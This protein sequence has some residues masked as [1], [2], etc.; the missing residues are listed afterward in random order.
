MQ[1]SNIYFF[2]IRD[3]YFAYDINTTFCAELDNIA[4]TIL[5]ELLSGA[6]RSLEKK[7]AHVYPMPQLHRCIKECKEL[8][9]SGCFGANP[10]TYKHHIHND[11]AAVCLH[12][13]HNCNLSCEYCYADTGAFGGNRQLMSRRIMFKAIDFAFAHS[14]DFKSVNV[15]FFGGEPLLNFKLIPEAVKYARN[16]ANTLNKKV[17]F[18]M[19]S[20]AMLLSP[21]IMDFISR[22]R[23]SL[24]FSLDGPQ[25][26]HDRMRKTKNSK[27][28]HTI[29][30]KNIREYF[31]HYADGFTVRGTFTRTTPNFSE[32]VLFLNNQGFKSVSVEPAQL[33]ETNPHS[34]STPGEITKI[35]YEYDKLA[36][37]YL[38]R[39]DKGNPIHFFH[40]DNCLKKILDPHP[41][42]TGCGAGS[43]FIAVV[44]DGRIFPCFE[45][46]PEKENSIGHIDSGFNTHKRRIFQRMHVDSKEECRKCWIK[47]FCGG[48]CHAFNVRYN[49]NI[50]NPYKPQCEFIKYRFKLSAWILSE[51]MNRGEKAVKKLKKHLNE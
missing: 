27:G 30:L 45:T 10:S 20:N 9:E 39:F 31:R 37:I 5:P 2:S 1:N 48:S 13:A 35:M 50:K 15:G 28:T 26:I 43:G 16:R 40:F 44:P 17:T 49:N 21:S 22:E 25:K 3:K 14:G 34:I 19:A 51:I 11:V 42:H 18:S 12:I 32:Q 7:Y 6:G 4:L 24:L 46:V 8:L 41:T 47:Y 23:F 36:D 38:E 29:V 33:A